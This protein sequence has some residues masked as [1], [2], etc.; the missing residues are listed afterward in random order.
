MIGEKIIGVFQFQQ[1]FIFIDNITNL[2]ITEFLI[3]KDAFVCLLEL[4]I[5]ETR[6]IICWNLKH[7]QKQLLIS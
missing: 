6:Q 2:E 5:F 7:A 1:T 4:N 3:C